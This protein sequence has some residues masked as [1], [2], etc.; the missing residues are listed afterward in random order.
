M[1]KKTPTVKSDLDKAIAEL[2]RE[3]THA[4]GD[5]KQYKK[6]QEQLTA[7]YA[8]RKIDADIVAP[9]KWRP[10]FVVP[11]VASIAGILIIVGYERMNVVTTKALNLI[12]KPS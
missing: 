2:L 11:A 12:M 10:E 9:M 6:L 5:S 4:P 1:F 8:L 7:L 3:M